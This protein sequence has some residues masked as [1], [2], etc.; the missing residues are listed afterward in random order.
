M[1]AL[2]LVEL[3][4]AAALVGFGLWFARSARTVHPA[5]DAQVRVRF[6]DSVLD[7]AEAL[8]TWAEGTRRD[9]DRHVRPVLA[10]VVE[11]RYGGGRGDGAHEISAALFG[12]RLWPLVDPA[13]AF[14]D[15]LGAPGPGRAALVKILDTLEE[16]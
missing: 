8:V 10:R 14:T 4:A 11:D 3:L 2:R 6:A 15:D 7:H 12:E 1:V 9:W 16:S 5:R 13:A